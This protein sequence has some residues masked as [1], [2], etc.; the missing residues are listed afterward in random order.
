MKLKIKHGD[1][2]QVTTGVDKG[3]SGSVLDINPL[4]LKIKVQGVK[5]LTHYDRQEGLVK[6]ESY[7][8]Y[9]NVKLVKAAAKTAKATKK[10]TAKSTS[11]NA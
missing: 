7:I 1:T 6:K 9:S 8:D 10:S 11:K 5:M 4:K 2:V 3:K